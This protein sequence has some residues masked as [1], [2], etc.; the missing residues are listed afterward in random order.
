[1]VLGFQALEE[2][3]IQEKSRVKEALEEEQT[4]VQELENRLTHQKEVRT[5]G[6]ERQ[7]EP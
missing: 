2:N 6:R 4:R 1:M 3:F 7:L 5:S